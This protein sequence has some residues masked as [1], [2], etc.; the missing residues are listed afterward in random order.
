[1][2]AHVNEEHLSLL[3]TKKTMNTF[4]NRFSMLFVFQE[5][6]QN[7]FKRALTDHQTETLFKRN[8]E[9]VYNILNLHINGFIPLNRN[10][11]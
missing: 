9:N 3:I 1:M 8:D 11:N 5:L 7:S 6:R 2:I 4:E 10:I